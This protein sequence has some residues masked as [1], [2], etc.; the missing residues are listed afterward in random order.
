MNPEIEKLIDFAIVDGEIT[1]KERG[2]I[3]RKAESLGIDKDEV[4]MILDAKLYLAQKSAAISPSTTQEKREESKSQ[5]E[6]GH[7]KCPSCGAPVLSFAIQCSYC[8]HEFRGIQSATSIQRLYDEL[9]K[10]EESERSRERSWAQQIEGDLGIQRSVAS[11][12]A[13]AISSFPVPNTKEDLLEFLSIASSEAKKKL[14]IFMVFNHPDAIIK[15]AWKSKCEQVIMKVRFSMNNDKQT[16]EKIEHY[17]KEL[18]I[19]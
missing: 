9:Q 18:K 13:S 16:L 12:Q 5:K 2:V 11:R 7:K 1:D 15:K 4:E 14:S 6:V 10:I 17:A 3:L 19:K 8:S